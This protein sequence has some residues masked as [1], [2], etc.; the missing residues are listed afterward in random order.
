[1][2]ENVIKSDNIPQEYYIAAQALKRIRNKIDR[3][4]MEFPDINSFD[5]KLEKGIFKKLPEEV[6]E[7]VE[8]MGLRICNDYRSMLVTYSEYGYIKP[9]YHSKEYEIIH[10]L[11]G[12]VVDKVSCVVYEEGDIIKINKNQLHHIVAG[13]GKCIM[14]IVFSNKK[15]VIDRFYK[16]VEN[17]V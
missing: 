10:I 3:I 15:N 2:R 17:K 13:D 9:H 12:E 16:N 7:G 4:G 5:F 8:T 11:E 6:S 1:M 14:H